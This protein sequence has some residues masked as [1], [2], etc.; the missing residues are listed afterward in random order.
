MIPMILPLGG[1]KTVGFMESI[2]AIGMVIGSVVIS[3]IGIK[4][5]YSKILIGALVLCGCFMALVGVSNYIALILIAGILFFTTLP[6]I[7]TCA[8]VLIR[9]SIPNEVQGRVWG[10]ISLLT[11]GGCVIAYATCGIL[12][13]KIFEPMMQKNGLLA[14]SIGKVIGIGEGRGIG[15]MLI[16]AGVLMVVVA[17]IFATNKSISY[18]EV[19][20]YEHELKNIEE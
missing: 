17:L 11:Q 14:D 3:V 13:D 19:I 2:S 9:V 5:S 18:I 20:N 10:L 4:K 8:D 7:N 12:A 15:L 6:F 16:I 1:A